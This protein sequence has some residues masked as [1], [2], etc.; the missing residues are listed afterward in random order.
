LSA[1]VHGPTVW[2]RMAVLFSLVIMAV[3]G[4]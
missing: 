4:G 1:S 2:D 3:S